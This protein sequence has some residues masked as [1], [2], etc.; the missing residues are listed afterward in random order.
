MSRELPHV[1]TYNHMISSEEDKEQEEDDND[2]ES[3]DDIDEITAV[4]SQPLD[5]ET[6]VNPNFIHHYLSTPQATN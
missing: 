6:I 2:S 5:E 4:Q 3:E 1:T